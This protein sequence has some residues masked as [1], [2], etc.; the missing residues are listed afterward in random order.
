MEDGAFQQAN[1]G[2][3]IDAL[4]EQMARIEITPNAGAGDGAQL[5]HRLRTVDYESGMHF[6]R[7][8]HTVI[9][10]KFCMFYPIGRDYFG[11]LPVENFEVIGRPRAGDPVGSSGMKRI[12]GT[13]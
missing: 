11:P 6:D 2:D 10:G 13:A 5:E 3:G 7:D 9:G 4:P 1:G 12:A 8:L